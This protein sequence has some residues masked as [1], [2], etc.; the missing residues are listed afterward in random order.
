L[1]EKIENSINN[2]TKILIINNDLK[3][4][5]KSNK[6]IKEEV[7][8]FCDS[9]NNF[10]N[11]KIITIDSQSLIDEK[12]INKSSI[13][14]GTEFLVKNYLYQIKNIETIA[15]LSIDNFIYSNK[16]EANENLF[17]YITYFINISKEKNIKNLLIQTQNIDNEILNLAIDQNYK[18]FY[19]KEINIRKQ[20]NFPP[21]SQIIELIIKEKDYTKLEEKKS[22]IIDILEKNNIE[23]IGEKEIEKELKTKI[24][25]QENIVIKINKI[26]ET[27]EILKELTEYCLI[28][29]K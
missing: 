22:K 4:E 11:K 3:T 9:I 12:E 29:V 5:F 16:I 1:Q 20:L 26:T 28:N 14:I 27:E 25:K 10:S 18:N 23:I 2:N 17:N 7:E 19:E 8:S 21:F 6:K 13:I 24:V 15:I